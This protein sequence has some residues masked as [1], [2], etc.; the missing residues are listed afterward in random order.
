MSATTSTTQQTLNFIIDGLPYVDV[1]SKA[2]S[3]LS[4][5]FIVDGL[6]FISTPFD[7][8]TPPE[9]ETPAYVKAAFFLLF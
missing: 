9:P 2:L 6:P 4:L 8:G 5:N 7:G 1:E 3:S